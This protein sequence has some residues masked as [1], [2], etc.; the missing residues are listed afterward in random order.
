MPFMIHE[1][2]EEKIKLHGANPVIEEPRQDATTLDYRA[3]H[4]QH[5]AS[6]AIPGRSTS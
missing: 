1:D 2:L 4:P 6:V 3:L 5:V